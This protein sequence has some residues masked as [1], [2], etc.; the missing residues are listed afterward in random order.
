MTRNP[1]KWHG[2]TFRILVNFRIQHLLGIPD[3]GGIIKMIRLRIFTENIAEI[4]A[5]LR[6]IQMIL[7]SKSLQVGTVL[8]II[9]CVKI[10]LLNPR[11]IR[12]QYITIIRNPL[13]HPVMAANR[14]KIPDF[15]S[16]GKGNAV[17]FTGAILRH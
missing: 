9:R 14:F 17:T 2:P 13:S 15:I 7:F 5:F 3:T 10:N 6:F 4:K 16:I 11:L 1:T 12:R 8:E